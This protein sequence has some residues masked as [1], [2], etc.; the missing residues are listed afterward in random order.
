MSF[1]VLQH[2]AH[3][4]AV[5][6]E[7]EAEIFGGNLVAVRQLEEDSNFSQRKLAFEEVLLQNADLTGVEAVEAADELDGV[8]G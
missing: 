7:V 8:G 1:E 4:A 5:E 2:A 6:T 3:I